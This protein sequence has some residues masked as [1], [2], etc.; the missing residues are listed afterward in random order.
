MVDFSVFQ[1]NILTFELCLNSHIFCVLKLQKSLLS[2][3]QFLKKLASL[4]HEFF[5]KREFLS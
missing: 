5:L 2:G 1:K 4:Y 3:M